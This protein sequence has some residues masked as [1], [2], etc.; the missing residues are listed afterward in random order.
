MPRFKVMVWKDYHVSETYYKTIK[1]KNAED[2]M[3][4][5]EDAIADGDYDC[6]LVDQEYS[7]CTIEANEN[8]VELIEEGEKYDIATI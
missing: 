7:K 8:S 4:L 5:A 2:A 3:A 1:A 6:M